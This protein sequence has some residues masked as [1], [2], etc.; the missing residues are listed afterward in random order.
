[1]SNSYGFGGDEIKEESSWRY[2]LA[3]FFSTLILCAIFLYHYV[4]P[5]VDEI[6][7]ATPKPT[8]SEEPIR[9]AV[10][11]IAL[12]VPANYTVYPKDRRGGERDSLSLYALWPTMN[13]YSPA[14]RADFIDNDDDT[15]RIDIILDERTTL[16]DEERRLQA[17]YLPHTVDK[18]GSPAE[19]GL[20]KFT[21]KDEGA[22]TTT[23]GYSDKDMF[24]AEA[25]DGSPIVLFCFRDNPDT[26]IP[27]D[28]W[29]QYGL[30]DGTSVRYSFKRSYLPEWR[31]I[32]AAV[33]RFLL[34]MS[35]LS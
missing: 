35:D 22:D 8:I 21:F 18:T 7:G 12:N 2:P 27:P 29:R 24:V 6:Q 4:G 13:G 30:T 9:L 10:G 3:I 20:V 5:G 34:G 16:F 14:R 28:C 32:D 33:R 25:E 31:K 17:L 1:M 26:V 11:D 23:N 15:R 19:Y